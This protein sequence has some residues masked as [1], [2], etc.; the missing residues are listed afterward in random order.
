M[1]SL[2][3]LMTLPIESGDDTPLESLSTSSISGLNSSIFISLGIGS[4]ETRR[5][6]S[7]NDSLVEIS[8]GG[9]PA[10]REVGLMKN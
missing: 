9:R 10:I 2:T 6:M 4:D 3:T 8:F 5:L 1:S 7:G